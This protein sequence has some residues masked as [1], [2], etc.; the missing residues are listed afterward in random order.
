MAGAAVAPSLPQISKIFSG[1]PDAEFLSKLILTIPALVIAIFAPM[2]GW[3]IDRFGKKKLL[4]FS[5]VLYAASGTSGLYLD[6]LFALLIGRAFLGLSVSGTMT[7]TIALIADYFHGA[8]RNKFIGLQGSAMGVGGVV[9]AGLGGLFADW[10]WR[11][12]FLIYAFSLAIIPLAV[13]SIYNVGIKELEQLGSSN[14]EEN[15]TVSRAKIILIYVV[16]FFIMLV[17]YMIPVQ[18]PFLLKKFQGVSNTK[19]GLAI[20]IMTACG[21]FIAYHY[22]KFRAKFSFQ[23]IYVCAFLLIA[24]GYAVI[25]FSTGYYHVVSGLA[26]SGVGVGLTMPNTNLWLINSSPPHIRGRLVGG[27][28]SSLFL[29]QFFS[30]LISKPVISSGSIANMFG[31]FSL[32][33]LFLAAFFLVYHIAQ[34]NEE[35]G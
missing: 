31:Y 10:H 12:P 1:N 30:P 28:T 2:A 35:N 17:F 34:K 16:A 14:P 11:L 9:F 22:R 8:E 27:L 5:L 7:S 23:L 25:S 24:A 18:I 21:A 26:I 32:F 4:I 29:G 3:F 20:S 19:T 13:F 15:L 6:S 33:L